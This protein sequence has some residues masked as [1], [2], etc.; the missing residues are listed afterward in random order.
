MCLRLNREESIIAGPSS[1]LALVGALR[2]VQDN[3]DA[4]VVVI[5]PDNIFKYASS[6]QRH[7]SEMFSTTVGSPAN[8]SSKNKKE[9]LLNRMIDLA[10][11]EINT[12]SQAEAA[13]MHRE[14]AALF[15]DVRQKDQY[16]AGHIKGAIHI[17]MDDFEIGHPQLPKNYDQSIVTVCN[18]G[19]LSMSGMLIL[20]S[21]GYKNTRSLNGG[22]TAWIDKGL[23]TE[24]T[25]S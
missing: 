17:P 20:K 24:K 18:K 6:I 21:I 11:N 10:R 23:E 14:M 9:E 25:A 22:T 5:F 7:F 2:I 16:D 3:P 8:A 15:V 12:V 19:N 13:K 1:G 4:V